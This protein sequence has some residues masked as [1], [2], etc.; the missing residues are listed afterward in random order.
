MNTPKVF[1]YDRDGQ[2]FIYVDNLGILLRI[3]RGEWVECDEQGN[4]IT[5]SMQGRNQLPPLYAI[6]FDRNGR[7]VLWEDD[8]RNIYELDTYGNIVRVP[9]SGVPT[10]T[11][12][13]APTGNRTT[14]RGRPDRGLPH[15]DDYNGGRVNMASGRNIE[16]EATVPSRYRDKTATTTP[17]YR[18]SDGEA[19]PTSQKAKTEPTNTIDRLVGYNPERNSELQP[20]YCSDTHTLEIFS[21][22]RDMTFKYSITKL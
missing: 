10:N 5:Q 3:V 13:Q 14:G 11:M 17:N 18:R 19:T 15:V 22:E 7:E 21:N 2:P 16:T 9:V 1:S 4:L 8:N 6:E 20:Y 12:R